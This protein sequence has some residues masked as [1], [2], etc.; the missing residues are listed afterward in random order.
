MKIA[1]V[2]STFFP[3]TGGM[4][5]VCFDE[6]S[7]LTE[8][9]HEV[10][11]FTLRYPNTPKEEIKNN[12]KIFRLQPV[13]RFGDA[14]VALRLFFKLKNFN[15]V[16][17]HYPFYGSA[18]FVWLA[19]LVFGQRYV[20][21]YHMDA[22]PIGFLKNL[23][24]K[25]YDTSFAK[26]VL[27]GAEKIIAVDEAHIKS[28]EY[29]NLI[30]NKITLVKNAVDS[31]VFYK[32]DCLSRRK[33]MFGED[34]VLGFIGNPLPVKRLDLL[35]SSIAK[36]N[37]GELSLLVVGGG[38]DLEKYKK[39]ASDSGI[40]HKVKFIGKCQSRE[41]L[42]EYYNICDAVVV[43][44]DT[45]S[46]SLVAL[47]SMACGTPVIASDLP[48]IASKIIDKTNGLTFH[49]G[50]IDDL[51]E[52]IKYFYSLSEQ[53]RKTMGDAAM[54]YVKNNFS[55]SIHVNKLLEVYKNYA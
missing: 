14:G 9:G 20:I 7:K 5:Q 15:I 25:I 21:T 28:C 27:L 26:R 30:K 45:E 29:Y 31:K 40:E 37:D 19:K 38:Y 49:T 8:L 22:K 39:H 47:E 12:F 10:S 33:E 35:I 2:V 23:L 1:H 50:S 52:K 36:I 16:H 24:L 34:K 48:V 41:K 17:L 18:H 44:S 53:D 4:G 3:K 32:R 54:D 46:F 55:Y 11:V 6:S 51:S 13:F 42:L 43:P